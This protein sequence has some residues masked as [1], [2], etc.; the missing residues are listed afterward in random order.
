MPGESDRERELQQQLVNEAEARLRNELGLMQQVGSHEERLDAIRIRID[1]LSQT[2]DR[3]TD[4]VATLF[5]RDRSEREEIKVAREAHE[6]RRTFRFGFIG[7]IVGLASIV[8]GVLTILHFAYG[9][10]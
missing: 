10:I 8:F 1:T 7:A 2:I 9:I 6:S 3:L 5:E 4:D